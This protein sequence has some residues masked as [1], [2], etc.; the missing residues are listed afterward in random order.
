MDDGGLGRP[1][2]LLVQPQRE[3]Q[4]LLRVKNNQNHQKIKLYGSLTT[5]D[6]KKSH[7]SRLVGGAE[8]WRWVERCRYTI[9]CGEAA[10]AVVAD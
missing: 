1:P 9:C 4:L 8:L 3:S 2:C 5:E 6:L 10:A 7:S